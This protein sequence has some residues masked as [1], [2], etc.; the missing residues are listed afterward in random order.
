M[1]PRTTEQFQELRDASKQKIMDAALEL[2][3]TKGFASTSIA[4][5]VKAAGISKGLVYHYFDSKDDLLEQLV[6]YLMETGSE[7]VAAFGEKKQ[8]IFQGEAKDRLKAMMDLFFLEMRENYRSW[9]LILN[10][11]VQVHHFDFI[12]TMVV[13]KMQGYV[14][15]MKDLFAELGY[16]NPEAEARILGALFDGMGMQYYVLNDEEYL[17][18]MEKSIYEKYKLT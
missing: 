1:S 8:L 16:K 13:Q 18:E 9:S 6:Q 4:D 14:A 2:F 7:K 15:L 10:L 17:K 11:T 12:H 3:G 5:I